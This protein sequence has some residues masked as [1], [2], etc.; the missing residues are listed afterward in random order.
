MVM[1]GSKTNGSVFYAYLEVV[2]TDK[3]EL[4][5]KEL[6]ETHRKIINCSVRTK[7]ENAHQL[8]TNYPEQTLK[9]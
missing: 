2:D 8:Q 5:A 1:T 7:R 3:D 4:P 6:T 9:C